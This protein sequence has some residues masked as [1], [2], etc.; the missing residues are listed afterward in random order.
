LAAVADVLKDVAERPCA[1][2]IE[3]EAGI[4]KTTVWLAAVEQARTRGMHVLC[5]RSAA[6]ESVLS[7]AALADLMSGVDATVLASL[8][9]PQQRA[10]DRVLLRGGA[11]D[12]ATDPRAVAAGFLSVIDIL[13]TESPVLV[14]IDDFQWL[15]TSSAGALAFAFPRLV[16]RVGLLTTVRTDAE[17]GHTPPLPQLPRPDQIRRIQVQPLSVGALHALL[18][19]RLGRTYSRP[20][21]VR[22]HEVSAGNP[23]YALELARSIGDAATLTDRPLP[24]TLDDVVRTRVGGLD[25]ELQGVLLAAACAANPTVELVARTSRTSIDRA[26]ELLEEAEDKG[27]VGIE[28][29]GVRFTHPLLAWGL[30]TSASAAKRRVTH[31]RLAEV[32]EE[33]ELRARHLALGATS[34]DQ[35][36]VRSLDAAAESARN[37]GAPAAAAELTDLAIRL[38]GDTPQRRIQSAHHHFQAGEPARARAQLEATIA[39]L[40]PGVLRA[41]ATSLLAYIRL[42][43]DSFPEAAD[44]LE[45]ALPDATGHAAVLV[46]ILI[47]L[48]FAL[49]NSGRLHDATRRAEEAVAH[50]EQVGRPDLLSQALGMRAMMTFLEGDGC[51]EP[52]LRRA[53]ELEDQQA[54][55]PTALRPTAQHAVI[56]ACVGELDE[57]HDTMRALRRQCIER[58][59]DGELMFVAF[60]SAMTEVWRGNFAEAALTV[61][62]TVLLA[63][64]LGGDLPKS[65]ALTTRAL[66]GAYTGR[67]DEARRDAASAM[68]ASRRCGS[69]LLGEWPRTALGFLEASLGNHQAALD[70]LEPLLSKLRAMPNATEIIAASFVADA[71]E[72]MVALDRCPSAVPLVE[73][74]ERNGRRLDRAWMLAIGGRGRAMLSA[75]DG[76]VGAAVVA[77]HYAM[78]AHEHL[79]MPFERARTQLLLGQLQRRQRRKE[80][81]AATLRDALGT[82]ERLG[83]PLWANRTRAELGRANIGPHRDAELTPSERRVAELAASGMTNRSIAA[84]MFISPK[85][86]EA[87]LSRIYTKLNIH[88][89]AELGRHMSRSEL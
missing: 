25:T 34:G 5:A 83:T 89:R 62:D 65:V 84:A 86:V 63:H 21:M 16:G 2:L 44:L 87:N 42:L 38:G 68:A 55:I 33:P 3:G 50:A 22:I 12:I 47:T 57:A 51:D 76:D 80:D 56:R 26:V 8:P 6:A 69:A 60:H 39:Q 10:M 53:V 40:T 18:H 74:L 41:E 27:I 28:G 7:Y 71:V 72:A 45:G 29:N 49:F 36:T 11:D 43:D 66:L 32:I 31:R 78:S 13:A 37:R 79:P 82:F 67:V 46:P 14:A 75:A 59:H 24:P 23:L 58:G 20:T 64:Q 30:Y 70:T 9:K 52:S 77:A 19:E 85:T 81:A 1:L 73:A 48:S 15:D 4:G 35:H 61:E 88:S 54:N 17:P